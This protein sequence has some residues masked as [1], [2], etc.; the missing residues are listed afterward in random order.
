[1]LE[2]SDKGKRKRNQIYSS[3]EEREKDGDEMFA[4]KPK[5]QPKAVNIAQKSKAG[6]KTKPHEKVS[7]TSSEEQQKAV[8]NAQKSSTGLRTNPINPPKGRLLINK[9]HKSS[10]SK[11]PVDP[12]CPLQVRV[13]LKRVD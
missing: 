5:E 1:M 11:F 4:T 6:P 12:R 13:S 8:N 10:A 2:K 3:D 7:V 9:G